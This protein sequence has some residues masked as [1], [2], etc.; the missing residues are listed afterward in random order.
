MFWSK[1]WLFLLALVAAAAV[2]AA[3]LVPRPA[4]RALV[5]GEVNRLQTACSVI[6]ILLADDA[7]NR[8]D[9]AGAFA[10][11]PEVMNALDAAS[12]VERLDE[13]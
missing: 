1:I 10:R 3:L 11:S 13:A 5:R 6:H 2:T 7:R 9:L 8:V 4:Q 12:G